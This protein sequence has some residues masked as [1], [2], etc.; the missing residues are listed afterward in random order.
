MRADSFVSAPP[1]F[2]STAEKAV[3]QDVD[4][5][6]VVPG[7]VAIDEMVWELPAGFRHHFWRM[8][9]VD[10]D[11]VPT[12]LDIHG[13]AT[14]KNTA[15]TRIIGTPENEVI[16]VWL[17][18]PLE[19]NGY[20]GGNETRRIRRIGTV[21]TVTALRYL[22]AIGH[23]GG[24]I[25]SDQIPYQAVNTDGIFRFSIDQ[26]LATRNSNAVFTTFASVMGIDVNADVLAPGLGTLLYPQD[27]IDYVNSVAAK[28]EPIEAAA[29]ANGTLPS[30]V[31]H[32]PR[33]ATDPNDPAYYEELEPFIRRTDLARRAISRFVIACWEPS[34]K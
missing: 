10:A 29:I 8:T 20:A 6:G 17:D 16:S 3:E 18:D 4:L 34:Q 12:I 32:L 7:K 28:I 13:M 27:Q 2:M 23:I 22:S 1:A 25:N 19:F 31:S 30:I 5:T 9:T 33:T 24:E 21:D 15:V 11:G 26:M 14:D